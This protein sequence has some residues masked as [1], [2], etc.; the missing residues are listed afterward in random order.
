M[1][2]VEGAEAATRPPTAPAL[3]RMRSV[4]VFVDD[5]E[6]ALEFYVG[7]LGFEVRGET[8][9]G[10]GFR[11]VTVAPPDAQTS[12]ALVRPSLSLLGAG[13]ASWARERM[14]EPTGVVF[15]TA[16]VEGA[17]AQLCE[18]G[19]RFAAPPSPRDWGGVAARFR[20]PDGNE[21]LLVQSS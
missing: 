7:T 17:Y 15:E 5:E 4:F 1:S 18:R 3:G 11:C 16:D 6:R 2:A 14:G 10:S 19:V 13:R 8:R 12:L 20:D 9:W 21:F